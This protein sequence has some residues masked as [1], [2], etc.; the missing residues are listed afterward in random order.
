MEGTA[1]LKIDEIP[2]QQPRYTKVCR[3]NGRKSLTVY[4]S[5]QGNAPVMRFL[6]GQ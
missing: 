4:L 2:V 5:M 1:W 6:R 3:V